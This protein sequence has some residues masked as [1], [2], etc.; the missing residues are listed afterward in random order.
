MGGQLGYRIK[1]T[2]Q[3]RTIRKNKGNVIPINE[4]NLRRLDYLFKR[5]GV[6]K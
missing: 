3:L 6:I 1:K 2:L 5:Y 4:K